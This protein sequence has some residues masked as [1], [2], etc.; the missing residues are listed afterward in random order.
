[1]SS[2]EASFGVTYTSISSDYEE[3][4]DIG[5]RE[6]APLL[7]DYVSGPEYP[8]Y[9]APSNE[10][11]LIEEQP[12][13]AID[14]PITLSPGYITDSNPEDESEDGHVDYPTDGGDD[15]DDD[16]SSGDDA[17]DED[18]E[19]ASDDEEEEEHLAPADSTAA[20]YPIMD[21]VPSTE[22]TKPFKTD[23]SVEVDR[24]LAIPT[25]PPSPLT[26]LSSPLPMIPSP[27]LPIPSP[28][29]TSPTYAEAPE[30]IP[31]ADI[32]PQKR[33][34][35]TTRTSRFEVEENDAP[36]C[37]VPREIRYG[38]T[39]TWDELV[40]AIQEG[41]PTTLEGVNAR[42][43]KLAETHEQDTQ[44]LY[45]NLEDTQDSRAHLSSRVDILI[46]DRQFHQQ[47]FMMIEDEA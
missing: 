30:D 40:D 16:D 37:Y 13:A 44:D 6:Q 34:C 8:E 12:Y 4:S 5:A 33:L 27:P 36:R 29:A 17:D 35:L 3:L 10:E 14:S 20:A 9:F 24:L 15:D 22:E 21:H 2:D 26:P 23:E 7:L 11:V 45:A 38:I 46:E 1:M 43:T 19:E 42:V 47:T 25:P 32:P 28:L 41:A 39:D 31:E 18:E